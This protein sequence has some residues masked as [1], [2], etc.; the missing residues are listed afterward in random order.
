M[1]TRSSKLINSGSKDLKV[2]RALSA[3]VDFSDD[4]FDLLQLSGAW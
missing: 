1:I 2:L 4:D 3:S